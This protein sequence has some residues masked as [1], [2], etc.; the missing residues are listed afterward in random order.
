V[1]DGQ[2]VDLGGNDDIVMG[3]GTSIDLEALKET[4]SKK[5]EAEGGDKEKKDEL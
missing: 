3:D 4:L 5:M 2:E 1:I